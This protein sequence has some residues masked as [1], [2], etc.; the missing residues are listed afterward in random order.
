[1][2]EHIAGGCGPGLRPNPWGRCIPFGQGYDRGYPRRGYDRGY[3]G[4]YD[5][6][7]AP[8]YGYQPRVPRMGCPRGMHP[9]N[10]GRC[11]PNY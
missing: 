3:G 5:R 9:G 7:D 8:R 4:G 6:R 2:V 11:V 1:M 10:S